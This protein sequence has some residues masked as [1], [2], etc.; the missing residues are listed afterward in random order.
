MAFK[1]KIGQKSTFLIQA[2]ILLF[3]VVSLFG[4]IQSSVATFWV[5]RAEEEEEEDEGGGGWG[6]ETGSQGQTFLPLL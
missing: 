6:S 1:P 5:A 3:L 2:L 4:K